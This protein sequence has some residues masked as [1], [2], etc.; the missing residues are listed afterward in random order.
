MKIKYW[1]FIQT[2]DRLQNFRGDKN[3]IKKILLSQFYAMSLLKTK[4]EFEI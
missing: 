3:Y 2:R 1:L 4:K